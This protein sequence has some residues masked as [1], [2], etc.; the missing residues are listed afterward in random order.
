MIT[1][2]LASVANLAEARLAAAGGAD[3]VDLKNPVAGALGALPIADVATIVRVLGGMRP[4][5]ATV[6]DLPMAPGV[7]APAIAAM[8]ATGVDYVK[9]GFFPGGD[10][11]GVTDSLRPLA[12]SGIR[13]IGVFFADQPL[14]RHW[15][16]RLADAGFTGAMLDTADKQRG[17]LTRLRD[18]DFL[19]DFVDA[20]RSLGLLCGLAGS[21]RAEDIETLLPMGADY[22]GF[23]GALCG[24]RRTDALDAAAF[25]ALRDRLRPA[26]RVPFEDLP[27]SID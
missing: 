15:L 12:L 19:R 11:P 3:I 10:W 1:G 6:G 17:S 20:S 22:L 9:L 16:D 5:S 18:L 23:R 7:V 26:F 14:E 13:L 24:G 27:C 25:S 21:L 8:A 4:I 2:M